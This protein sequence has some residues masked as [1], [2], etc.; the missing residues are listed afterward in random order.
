[1]DKEETIILQRG[2][3]TVV[4]T[5]GS[6]RRDGRL[7][8]QTLER[9]DEGNKPRIS[10][11]PAGRYKCVRHGWEPNSTVKFKN[12]WRL[13]DVPGR[14]AILIH[15]G[16]TIRDTEGCILVGKGVMEDS[17]T[18][19]RDALNMLR[20]TLPETFFIEIRDAA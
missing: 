9:P 8:C 11:I 6:L 7:L 20:E 2:R 5:F 12:V 19:S 17:I 18:Q 3:S 10:S 13:L 1:M 4:G 15:A 14:E 16:N